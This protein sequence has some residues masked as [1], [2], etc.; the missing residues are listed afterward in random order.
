VL[1]S[2]WKEYIDL[3]LHELRYYTYAD[4]SDYRTSFPHIWP[5]RCA[6]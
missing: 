3:D 5:C 6:S 1:H 4:F 2:N